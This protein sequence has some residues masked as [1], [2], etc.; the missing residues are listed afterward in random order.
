MP[1]APPNSLCLSSL[2]YVDRTKRLLEMQNNMVCVSSIGTKAR[3]TRSRPSGRLRP[4]RQAEAGEAPIQVLLVLLAESAVKDAGLAIHH[5]IFGRAIGE[6]RILAVRQATVQETE[7]RCIDLALQ[8]LEIIGLPLH[9]PDAPLFVIQLERLEAGK[10]GRGLPRPHIDPDESR[11]FP[12]IVGLRLDAVVRGQWTRQVRCVDTVAC[13]VELPTMIDAANTVML[14][15]AKEKRRAAM[16]AFL[17]HDTDTTRRIAEGDQLLVEKFES[18][19]GPIRRKFRRHQ[20][21]NPVL[22]HELTHRRSRTNPGQDFGIRYRSHLPFPFWR[23]PLKRALALL[24]RPASHQRPPRWPGPLSMKN[25][26][27]SRRPDG[28]G[29]IVIIR[30]FSLGRQRGALFAFCD[31]SSATQLVC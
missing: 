9:A 23:R 15:A 6:S 10:L 17:I 2:S 19:W 7:V 21:R 29:G 25:K 5:L 24:L 27:E 20:R 31:A 12:N 22:P 3:A 4:E 14:V 1:G 30:K 16:R 26:Y 28:E 18:Q 11:T 13:H 8:G